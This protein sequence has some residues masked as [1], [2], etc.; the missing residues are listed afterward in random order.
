MTISKGAPV[1]N[2][3]KEAAAAGDIELPA[4]NPNGIAPGL[5][6]ACLPADPTEDKE[7]AWPI[8][9]SNAPQTPAFHSAAAARDGLG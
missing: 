9:T 4:N 6:T 1:C 7:F 3:I 2:G 5:N 8:D